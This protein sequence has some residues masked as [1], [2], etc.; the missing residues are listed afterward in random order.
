M[1]EATMIVQMV[2]PIR[3]RCTKYLKIIVTFLFIPFSRDKPSAAAT[4]HSRAV[5]LARCCELVVTT[6][7]IALDVDQLLHYLSQVMP[8]STGNGRFRDD[9]G[10]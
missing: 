3:V 4:S 6:S 8:Y 7:C 2:G 5:V 1:Q 9:A 10:C